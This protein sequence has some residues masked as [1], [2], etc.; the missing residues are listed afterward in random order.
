MI[1]VQIVDYT[2]LSSRAGNRIVHTRLIRSVSVPQQYRYGRFDAIGINGNQVRIPVFVQVSSHYGDGANV[3]CL[4]SRLGVV[5]A[6]DRAAGN[7]AG[8]SRPSHKH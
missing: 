2:I 8:Q 5:S 7:D 6:D 4:R 1:A 3:R